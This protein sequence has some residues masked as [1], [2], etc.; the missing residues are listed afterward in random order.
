MI[1]RFAPSL[2]LHPLERFI[3]SDAKRF[4]EHANV[5]VT[6][7]PFDDKTRWGGSPTSPF[8]RSPAVAAGGLSGVV[9]E[10]GTMIDVASLS[11]PGTDTHLEFGG[12]LDANGVSEPGVT[13]TSGNVFPDRNAIANRYA[14]EQKLRDSQ[15]WYHGEVIE[16]ARLTTLV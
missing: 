7:A 10:P 12:W 11:P 2:F 15:Y 9:G 6:G 8:P 4:M 5:W 1:Q 16:G 3:P 14:S 13:A